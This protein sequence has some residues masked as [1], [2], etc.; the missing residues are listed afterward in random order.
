MLFVFIPLASHLSW[1]VLRYYHTVDPMESWKPCSLPA[2]E[3]VRRCDGPSWALK[4]CVPFDV[5]FNIGIRKKPRWSK[6]I[7]YSLLQDSSSPR[8]RFI[9]IGWTTWFFSAA[10]YTSHVHSMFRFKRRLVCPQTPVKLDSGE[11]RD[12]MTAFIVERSFGGVTSGP[13]EK[14]MGIKASN[15][16]SV[17]FDNTPVPVENVLGN[18][19]DGFKVW[20][21]AITNHIYCAKNGRGFISP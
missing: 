7:S 5:F 12:R 13:P 20:A 17:Y 9:I 21:Y 15:T 2:L 4:Q 19:G 1:P 16:A 10:C 14:K 8:H 11:V 3:K 18:V 6:L